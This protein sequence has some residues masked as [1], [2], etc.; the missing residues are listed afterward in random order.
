MPPLVKI[1]QYGV[2]IALLVLASLGVWGFIARDAPI[3]NALFSALCIVAMVGLLRQVAWGRFFVSCI[4]VL[5]AFSIATI[6]T[7][8]SDDVYHGGSTLEQW[9]GHLPPVWLSW[10][11]VV[12]SCAAV[13]LP[14]VIIGW[15][16]DWFRSTLW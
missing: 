4:S 10:L 11:L 6:L 2:A 8:I 16:R 7:P 9:F 12:A 5:A 3:G 15:R 13:L 14:A 1:V